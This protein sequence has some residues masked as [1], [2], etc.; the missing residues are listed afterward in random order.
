M[1]KSWL[2]HFFS[3]HFAILLV[4]FP[5]TTMAQGLPAKIRILVGLA[6]GGPTDAAARLIAEQLRVR[7]DI[8]VIV[9]NRPGASAQLAANA[10]LSAAPDGQT[11]MVSSQGL[12][13]ISPHLMKLSFDPLKDFTPISGFVFTETALCV[14]KA[15]KVEDLAGFSVAAKT[16]SP[17]LA[18]GTAGQ[19]NITHLLLER[20]RE[21]MKFEYVPV[22]YKGIMQ[23][24]QDVAAG[25]ISGSIC[26]LSIALPL[27]QADLV[28]AI[29]VIGDQRSDLLPDVRTTVEQGVAVREVPW[30]GFFGPPNMPATTVNS[31]AEE[32]R[33][34]MNDPAT[35]ASLGRLGLK[36]WV[37][38][39]AELTQILKEES[40]HWANVIRENGIQQ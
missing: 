24:M 26:S 17:S 19:G 40:S 32:I 27:I 1:K 34:I 3:V 36:P 2:Y 9:D 38:S 33:E 37:K 39:P 11:L 5:G 4:L 35:I 6:A 8:V 25:Q 10:L 28:K 23:S 15:L 21:E 16:A 22:P 12:F 29:A 31:I 20:F 18:L 30:F 7:H 13:T 14:S